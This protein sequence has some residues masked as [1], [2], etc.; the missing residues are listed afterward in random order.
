MPERAEFDA[1]QPGEGDGG[2]PAEP[3]FGLRTPE[4]WTPP[5]S[6][7][8]AAVPVRAAGEDVVRGALFAMAVVPVGVAAWLVLWNMGWMASIVAFIAATLAARLYVLGTGGMISRRGAWVVTAV[9]LGTVLLSFWGGMLLDAAKYLGGGSP[10]TMLT[11]AGTWDLLLYNLSTNRDL[12]DG[13]AG[14][15]LVALLFSA[16]GCFFTLRQLFAHTRGS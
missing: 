15:F 16:L 10:L 7:S 14:D 6:Q 13:Y 2:A 11:D 3:Q 8:H 12:V 4:V 1:S 9:T 5:A